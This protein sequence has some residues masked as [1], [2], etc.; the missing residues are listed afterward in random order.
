[1]QPAFEEQPPIAE[2]PEEG[3]DEEPEPDTRQLKAVAQGE[4]EARAAAAVEAEAGPDVQ[5]GGVDVNVVEA[6]RAQVQQLQQQV[7]LS[8][9]HMRGDRAS[10]DVGLSSA[11]RFLVVTHKS[12][13]L[14]PGL[15]TGRAVQLVVVEETARAA[16][17]A[18]WEEL[19]ASGR[20]ELEEARQRAEQLEE[21]LAAAAKELAAAQR[22]AAALRREL[23]QERAARPVRILWAH[24]ACKP[25]ARHPV[26]GD[27]ST[28]MYV[29]I[30][31]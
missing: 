25:A 29:C 8:R 6:L 17:V 3:V 11:Q 2:A 19:V 31:V 15:S 23:A 16:A 20:D 30:S 9:L 28:C 14:Q 7:R 4:V 12:M 5:G 22:E 21:Q 26:C 18:E 1:M 10:S 24:T 13:D 27:C